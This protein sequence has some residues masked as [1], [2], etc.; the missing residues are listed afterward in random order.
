MNTTEYNELVH[1]CPFQK[2]GYNHCQKCN[3]WFGFWLDH[4][5]SRL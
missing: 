5:C 2:G 3:L 4:D 1:I